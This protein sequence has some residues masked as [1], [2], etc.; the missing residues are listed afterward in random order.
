VTLAAGSNVTITPSGQ[1]L[2]IAA[3]PGGGG[4]DITAVAAGSGLSGGG[5]SGDVTLSVAASGISSTMLADN[6]VINSK[7]ASGISYS[8][9]SGAPTAL[10][11][12]GAAGGG[13]AGTY[14]NPSLDT[15]SVGS[16]QIVDSSITSADVG[17]NYAASTAKGGAA[18]ELACSGCVGNLELG[19]AIYP[20]TVGPSASTT[21]TCAA[22]G[23][24]KFCALS[25]V[26]VRDQVD[27]SSNQWCGV[28]YDGLVW[29]LCVRSNGTTW[30]RCGMLCF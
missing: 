1:T 11:P 19:I 3:T 10:P 30:V 23:A 13:L 5:T 26:E 17:F 29:N 21:E 18:T 8:K 20:Y 14:P 22:A 12:N 15:N 7:V 28:K 16:A 25:M 2:T 24:K 9:L 4:G 27:S 6:S